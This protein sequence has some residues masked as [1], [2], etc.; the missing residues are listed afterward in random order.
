MAEALGAL[1]CSSVL[2]EATAESMRRARDF[3]RERSTGDLLEQV[4]ERIEDLAAAEPA[5]GKGAFPASYGGGGSCDA[6]L[7]AGFGMF[8]VTQSGKLMLDCTSGHYQ[9]T[10]GYD[11]PALTA[12]IKDAVDLGV[13]W[14]NH[15][16]IPGPPVKLL[17]ERLVSLAGPSGLDRVLLGVCTGSVACAAAIKIVL[18]RYRADPARIELGPPVMVTLAGNYHGTDIVAQ[19]MRGMWAG[20]LAGM[21]TVQVEPNAPEGLEGVFRRYGRRIAGFW[22]EPVMMN[23]EAVLVDREFLVLARDLCTQN[24]ALMVLDE[25]QTCFWYPEFFMFR[26]LGLEPDMV[27]VGKGMT[28]GFHPLAALIFRHELDV[29]AQYDAISTNGNASLAAFVGLCNIRLIEGERDRIARLAERH[30]NGVCGLAEDFPAIIE[31]VNGAGFLTGLKFRERE[32]ALGFHGA[33][34]ERGLWL[35]VHAYHPGHR[36]VLMKYPLVAEDAI[37]DYVLDALRELLRTTP[38]R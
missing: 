36:T 2:G 11:H 16:N 10:W 14:D 30:Y 19:T 9:M 27:V 24:D 17:A 1:N 31:Q 23:R 33:A 12:A 3:L 8:Y 4:G 28:G 22:A 18:T 15:S 35:R 25:I 37:V 26:E 6:D 21:E 20:L 13:V 7:L 38:W 29:L 34:V 5:A 32:D